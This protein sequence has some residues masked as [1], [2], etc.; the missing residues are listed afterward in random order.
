MNQAYTFPGG[1]TN[2]G[3]RA[4]ASQEDAQNS[5]QQSD[6]PLPE[7]EN[8]V[9]ENISKND[10]DTLESSANI[11][12]IELEIEAFKYFKEKIFKDCRMPT[13]PNY[14][15][16]TVEN[17][18]GEDRSKTSYAKCTL[19]EQTFY[20]TELELEICK[21]HRDHLETMEKK[22]ETALMSHDLCDSSDL[23]VGKRRNPFILAFIYTIKLK[24]NIRFSTRIAI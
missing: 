23:V 19:L 6:S 13:K 7:T 20:L 21:N 18:V 22:R 24:Q 3:D 16:E 9:L 11:T 1:R 8:Q 2:T 4:P 12:D 10:S 17:S 14:K 5:T 15:F